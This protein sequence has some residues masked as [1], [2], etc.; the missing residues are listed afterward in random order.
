M[1]SFSMM[2]PPLDLFPQDLK[3]LM[4]IIVMFG[5]LAQLILSIF[6]QYLSKNQNFIDKD[7]VSVQG[8][9]GQS[10]TVSVQRTQVGSHSSN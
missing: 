3:V 5:V 6:S 4:S 10:P 7:Y 2:E 1:G 8:F 9:R